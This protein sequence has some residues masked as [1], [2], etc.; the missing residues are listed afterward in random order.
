[1]IGMAEAV[2]SKLLIKAPL[3]GFFLENI[4]QGVAYEKLKLNDGKDT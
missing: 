1:M 4:I 2:F 3:G